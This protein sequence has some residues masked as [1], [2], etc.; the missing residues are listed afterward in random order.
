MEKC[1]INAIK[2]DKLQNSLP[3]GKSLTIVFNHH[4]F[5]F[6]KKEGV[7]E[8]KPLLAKKLK[9]MGLGVVPTDRKDGGKSKKHK[10]SHEKFDENLNEEIGREARTKRRNDPARKSEKVLE[11]KD[12][13][14]EKEIEVEK[15]PSL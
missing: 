6:P 9:L 12:K 2:A 1:F 3:Y 8:P 15:V 10:R 14:K 5:D 4:L 11:S 7:A 13:G